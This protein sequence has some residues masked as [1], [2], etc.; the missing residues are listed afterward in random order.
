MQ[1]IVLQNIAIQI[2]GRIK[3]NQSTEK[4]QTII[5]SAKSKDMHAVWR[6]SKIVLEWLCQSESKTTYLYNEKHQES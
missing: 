6:F 2:W 5:Y 3:F 4:S 1:Y